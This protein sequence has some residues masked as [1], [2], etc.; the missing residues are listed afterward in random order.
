MY[1]TTIIKRRYKMKFNY[2][3]GNMKIGKDTLI[4]NMGSATDCA[5]G[6]LGLCEL[7]KTNACYALKSEKH[8]PNVLPSRTQQEQYWLGTNAIDIAEDVHKAVS[9]KTKVAIKYVRVNESGDMHSTACLDKLI[10]IAEMLPDVKF[11][12]YTHR[13]DIIGK[14]IDLP[15]NLVI[16]TS[17]FTASGCNSFSVVHEVKVSS[18]KKEFKTARK[19]IREIKGDNALTCI[20]DC[21]KCSLCKIAHGKNIWI[22]LH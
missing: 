20:G 2:S 12:T 7:F 17:N 18:L 5:S 4:F 9:R 19:A 11:Y 1:I 14:G 8:Y 10:A 6:R 16:N 21:S 15:N 3:V 13:S 22:P